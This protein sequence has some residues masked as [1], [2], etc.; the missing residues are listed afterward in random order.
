MKKT[1]QDREQNRRQENC[2]EL[3]IEGEFNFKF[4]GRE[5]MRKMHKLHHS[6]SPTHAH[7]TNNGDKIAEKRGRGM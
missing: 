3:K 4:G 2:S 1:I 6:K 7:T 5:K